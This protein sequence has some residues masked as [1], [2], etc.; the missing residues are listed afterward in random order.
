M[1]ARSAEFDAALALGS[2]NARHVGG[3]DTARLEQFTV[4]EKHRLA[5]VRR[6]EVHAALAGLVERYEDVDRHT[7]DRRYTLLLPFGQ[8]HPAMP[9]AF[10]GDVWASAA[11]RYIGDVEEEKIAQGGLVYYVVHRNPPHGIENAEELKA[12]TTLD[13]RGVRALRYKVEQTPHE[14]RLPT[15]YPM[16]LATHIV[17][18]TVNDVHTE[19]HEMEMGLKDLFYYLGSGRQAPS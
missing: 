12:L 9:P 2:F 10:S 1:D 3:A 18:A 19:L 13:G 8:T 17:S 4:K 16:T 14:D 6:T 11:L 15:D 5:V 7:E